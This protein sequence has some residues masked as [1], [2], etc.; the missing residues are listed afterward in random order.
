MRKHTPW[1]A[2]QDAEVLAEGIISYSTAGHGGIWLSAGRQKQ[3][4]KKL[5][6]LKCDN[7]LSSTEWWEEDCDWSIPYYFFSEEIKNYG[8][9]YK[10]D[11]NLKSAKSIIE[12]YHKEIVLS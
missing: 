7:F 4:E 9:A 11:E 3:L 2:T 1:G 12:S 8:K 10:F 5:N 6:G